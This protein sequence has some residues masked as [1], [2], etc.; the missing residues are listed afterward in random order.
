M[1]SE[2][3]KS[4][5]FMEYDIFK[6]RSVSGRILKHSHLLN[7]LDHLDDEKTEKEI[8]GHSVEGREIFC[9]K[10]GSGKINILM[11]TQM[12][13]DEPVGTQAVFDMLNLINKRNKFTKQID[14][15]LSTV[16]LH[17]I[18]M[19]NPDGAERVTRR[20]AIGIDIN[21]DAVS[22]ASPEA[23]ALMNYHNQ[24][25]PDF[26]FNLHD[27]DSRYSAGRNYKSASIS[28]LAPPFNYNQSINPVRE[29]GMKLCAC[30][31]QELSVEAP[32]HIAKYDEEF[33]PRA[34]GD[35]FVKKG[36]PTILI[37]A[38]G[39]NKDPEKQFVRKLYF[40]AL[41]KAI[42]SISDESYMDQSLDLYDKIPLNK[43]LLFDLVL[44]NVLIEKNDSE[45]KVDIAVNRYPI[46]DSETNK[47]YYKSVIENIGDLSIFYG[48][49][50]VDMSGYK[51]LPGKIENRN[52]QVS[53]HE[54]ES[55]LAAGVLFIKSK[56]TDKNKKWVKLPVNIFQQQKTI[57]TRIE[58]ENCANFALSR[59]SKIQYV[60][61]NGY[62]LDLAKHI[63]FTG[64]GL[65]F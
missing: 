48:Y 55:L 60:V 35:N 4:S 14:D 15:I 26:C 49:E 50:D 31:F 54:L 16:T 59:K 5:L 34:F 40:M 23:K 29:K 47:I 37:E 3:L 33:E 17:I 21:R 62:F 1:R 56:S 64:N 2:K 19:L 52:S 36:T 24:L 38:G 46:Y 65:N 11:W 58:I 13:G 61:I 30:I 18:P 63:E 44:R 27:Q 42:R 41:V 32:G 9:L 7:Y 43:E 20:N 28:L 10:V 39:W 57:N 45:Y 22:L 25:K 8:I 53:I 12:H 6:E 51:V